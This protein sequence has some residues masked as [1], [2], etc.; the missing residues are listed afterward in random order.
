MSR[1]TLK[2]AAKQGRR[3]ENKRRQTILL[4]CEKRLGCGSIGL[5]EVAALAAARLGV[6]PVVGKGTQYA[7]LERFLESLRPST[8]PAPVV[9]EYTRGVAPE[10][11]R[12]IRTPRYTRPHGRARPPQ[13]PPPPLPFE[14]TPEFLEGYPWRR[15]R[16][17]VL[18]ARGA[19]CE[20]CGATP[21]DGVRMH[22]D[23]IKPRRLFPDLA[24]ERSNLQILCE[25]CN[26]GKGNWDHTD[27]RRTVDVM[28]DEQ[29]CRILDRPWPR[30][31][32]Q[33]A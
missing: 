3:Q 31:V 11:A 27:W 16:M 12:E 19:Q 14:A 1:E 15:L 6:R 4:T 7:L 22:V 26:H 8:P 20:C 18:R 32:K 21:Q 23:H 10:I 24:L 5:G 13:G 2:R 28:S 30:M 25:V 29:A 33:Q 9:R 17:E